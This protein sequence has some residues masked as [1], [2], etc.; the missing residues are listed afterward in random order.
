VSQAW[1]GRKSSEMHHSIFASILMMALA[2]KRKLWRMMAIS[3]N[4]GKYD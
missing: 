4:V 2:I 1:R 3:A